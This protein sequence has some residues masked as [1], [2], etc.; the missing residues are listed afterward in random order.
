[1]DKKNGGSEKDSKDTESLAE[2]AA[3]LGLRDSEG[4]L[5]LEAAARVQKSDAEAKAANA[6]VEA[7][8]KKAAEPEPVAGKK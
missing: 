7:E 2:L 6:R 1:M 8:A 3:R 4:K 5:D